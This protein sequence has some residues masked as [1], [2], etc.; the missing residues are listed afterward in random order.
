MPHLAVAQI[1]LRPAH[2]DHDMAKFLLHFLRS[3][4]S[5][6]SHRIAMSFTSRNDNVVTLSQLK[7]ILYA[8]IYFSVSGIGWTEV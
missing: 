2:R 5:G 8:K 3:I 7:C 1:P 6:T 4:R